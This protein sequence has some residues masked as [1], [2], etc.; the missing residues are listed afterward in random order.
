MA[1]SRGF[2]SHGCLASIFTWGLWWLEA[3]F[4]L[5]QWHFLM[6]AGRRVGSWHASIYP[7]HSYIRLKIIP[8]CPKSLVKGKKLSLHLFCVPFQ[9][10]SKLFSFIP[11]PQISHFPTCWRRVLR[12]HARG[13]IFTWW[14][15]GTGHG[16]PSASPHPRSW[17][18]SPHPGS[19][20]KS[21]RVCLG[22]S[23]R[24]A[25]LGN[26]VLHARRGEEV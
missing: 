18:W 6:V 16:S 11:F 17:S 25:D 3:G 12:P 5:T 21:T 1:F 24:N 14:W 15:W 7:F 23:G 20:R 8:S 2:L 9:E 13:G 4:G 26:T 10:A 19:W 22:R